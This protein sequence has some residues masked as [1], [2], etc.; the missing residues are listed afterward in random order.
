MY[1]FMSSTTPG[2]PIYTVIANK[3]AA[4]MLPPP[5][6]MPNIPTNIIYTAQEP[7]RPK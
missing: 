3:N 1:L 5:M 4:M 2:G 6:K 7:C